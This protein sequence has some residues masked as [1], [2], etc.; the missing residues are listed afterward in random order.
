MIENQGLANSACHGLRLGELV[1]A[2]AG[3]FPRDEVRATSTKEEEE[4]E[5]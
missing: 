2:E 4:F 3:H 1:A 5:A